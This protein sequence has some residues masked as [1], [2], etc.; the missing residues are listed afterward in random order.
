MSDFEAYLKDLVRDVPDFPM[1]GILFRDITPIL[2]DPEALKRTIDALAEAVADLEFDTIFAI[3]S[4][5]FIFGV[6]LGYALGKGVALVRKPGKLPARTEAVSYSLEYGTDTLEVH[7]DAV[8]S[9]QRVL[10]VDD[11]L[12]TGGTA[13]ATCEL[14][15]KLGA[16]VA[17]CLFL[18]E[19]DFLNGREKLAGHPVTSLVHY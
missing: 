13:A 7:T 15:E 4:R 14:A 19:L 17:S 18:I 12:A 9:G 10:I 11:L 6:A 1:A 16:T 2:Q 5:G 8:A 3:E